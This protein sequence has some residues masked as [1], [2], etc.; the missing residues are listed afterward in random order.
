MRPGRE[1]RELRRSAAETESEMDEGRER[2]KE[3]ERPP[4][5]S[6]GNYLSFIFSFSATANLLSRTL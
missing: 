5:D 2:E 3:R 4:T 6:R 1:D